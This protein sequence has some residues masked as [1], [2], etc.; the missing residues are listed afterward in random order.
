MKQSENR[1]KV[2]NIMTDKRQSVL[3]SEKPS[4][5][6]LA[7]FDST[8][9]E[10]EST[11]EEKAV[12]ERIRASEDYVAIEVD[13]AIEKEERKSRKK[14]GNLEQDKKKQ[15]FIVND[16]NTL[17]EFKRYCYLHELRI[18]DVFEALIA[19]F[20]KNPDRYDIEKK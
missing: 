11:A 4:Q 3:T 15:A 2:G 5:K 16:E 7:L 19:D 10:N 18:Q 17:K 9:P 13:Q 14:K 1:M 6:A 20:V 8:S 12:L